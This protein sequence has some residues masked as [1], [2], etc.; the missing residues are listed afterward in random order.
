MDANDSNTGIDPDQYS[1]TPGTTVNGGTTSSSRDVLKG[2]AQ[3][4]AIQSG[5]GPMYNQFATFCSGYDMFQHNSMNAN[6]EQV[7]LTFI[8]RPR[9]NL[10]SSAIKTHR[11]L[12]PLIAGESD[13]NSPSFMIRSLLDSAL[14]KKGE[15]A[16]TY[17]TKIKS[18]DLLDIH[19]P[20]MV[21][22]QN[23]LLGMSGWPDETIAV[24]T[25]P[26]GFHSEDQT[27]AVGSDDL[28]KTYDLNLD[29][30]DITGGAIAA[31]FE[32]WRYCIPC[33]AKGTLL[34]YPDDIKQRRLNYTVS[35]Y[36]FVLDPTRETIVR[37]AKATGCF[38]VTDAGGGNYNFG[39]GERFVSGAN[40]LSIPFKCNKIEYND[41][42]HLIEF[43]TLAKRYCSNI[44]DLPELP[45]SP[46]YNF[47]G[48]PYIDTVKGPKDII[49][50]IKVN[51][52]GEIAKVTLKSTA[53]TVSGTPPVVSKPIKQGVRCVFKLSPKYYTG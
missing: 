53:Q 35:I 50:D 20:F 30:K 46:G 44:E 4:S 23:A 7:G 47:M 21:P 11:R 36:R 5:R 43:N 48:I 33:L 42:M 25:T 37:W 39:E 15:L 13:V 12:A 51:E 8:T 45:L 6:I 16:Q 1:T 31:I 18:S 9:I 52:N 26:S 24:H 34:A 2:M 32:Y 28:N 19:S 3:K 27:F 38:P 17:H 10:Q 22:L 29:F 41:Y 14:H 40:K 49:D